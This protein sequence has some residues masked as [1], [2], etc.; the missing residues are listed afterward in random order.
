MSGAP[1]ASEH[2]RKAD[3]LIVG[4]G[5]SDSPGSTQ[6]IQGHAA[7]IAKQ[8]IFHDVK[9]GFI[10]L[11]PFMS[12]QLAAMQSHRI[13]IVPCFASPGTLSKTIIP[14][15]LGLSGPVTKR[16]PQTIYFTEPIGNHLGITERLGELLHETF[17]VANIQPSA[18]TVLVIGHG[19]SHN[20]Q[21][22]RD[23][24]K[25]ADQLSKSKPDLKTVALFIDQSPNL[26]DWQEHC[27][28]RN[29][30]IVSHLFSGGDHE[31]IDIPE[32]LGIAP[33]RLKDRLTR[34][35]PIGPIEIHGK[36]IWLSPPI[37][38]DDIVQ[39]I[40]IERAAECSQQ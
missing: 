17:A 9:A 33:E 37:S 3:L 24:Q 1:G 12:D 39:K 23:T 13:Y 5:R 35:A 26:V 16:G 4:H 22:E 20:R 6:L 29:V 2:F 18:T 34:A 36:Q 27:S 10:K 14:E 21:S 31:T 38:A 8:N 28:Q 19:S 25:I 7:A 15:E 32:L 40:I 30:I 11:A